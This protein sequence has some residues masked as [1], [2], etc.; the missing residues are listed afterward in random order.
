MYNSHSDPTVGVLDAVLCWVFYMIGS[1]IHEI[2]LHAQITFYLQNTSFII[3]IIVGLVAL[4]RNLG[5]DMNL[6]KRLKNKK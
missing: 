6:K 5:F 1:T 4:M 2:K 3:G